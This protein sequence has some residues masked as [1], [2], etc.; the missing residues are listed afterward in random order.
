MS[1]VERYI[2]LCPY[3]GE[4]TIRGFTVQVS[5]LYSLWPQKIHLHKLI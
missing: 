2:L 3:F 5:E 1:S 4:L